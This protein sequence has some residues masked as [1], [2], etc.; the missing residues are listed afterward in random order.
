M[1]PSNN[2]KTF[3][4]QIHFI[5]HVSSCY[6]TETE[7]VG[8]QLASLL[9]NKCTI[10]ASELRRVILKALILLRNRDLYSPVE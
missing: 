6:K 2:F 9:E 3:S 7:N 10:M 4:S 5:S 1:K 8:S